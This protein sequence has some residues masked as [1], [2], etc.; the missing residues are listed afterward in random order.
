L[1][2]YSHRDNFEDS[3][4]GSTSESDSS[5]D[6]DEVDDEDTEIGISVSA[7]EGDGIDNLWDRIQEKV[8]HATGNKH[9]MFTIPTDGPQL[10]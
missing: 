3:S 1:I 4:D 7:T 5:R 2:F 6:E 8:F 10:R 9:I